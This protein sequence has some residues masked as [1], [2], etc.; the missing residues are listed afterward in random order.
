MIAFN[1]FEESADYSLVTGLI[2]IVCRFIFQPIEEV[3]FLYISRNQNSISI[4]KKFL[5]VVL[6]IGFN[7]VIFA[8]LNGT[9]F[10]RITY[11]K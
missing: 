6:A 8:N 9:K 2:G 11:G 10:L 7:G 4:L 3:A 1:H 5:A